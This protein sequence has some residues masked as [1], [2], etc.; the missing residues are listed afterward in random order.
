MAHN[1]R[2]ARPSKVLIRLCDAFT[3]TD[4]NIICPLIKAEI[5]IRVLYKLQ[6]KV[7]YKA[8]QEAGTGIGL[9]DPTFLWKSAATGREMDGNLFVEY[10]NSQRFN[11]NLKQYRET[12]VRNLKEVLKVKSILIDKVEDTDEIIPQPIISETCFE[13][14]KLKLCSERLD[15]DDF[16]TGATRS[17]AYDTIKSH[18]DDL[19]GQYTKFA[20]LSQNGRG[21]SFILNL[22]MLLTA[23]FEEE[24][25]ENNLNLKLPKDIDE[26]VK[27]EEIEK[28][29][30]LPDV[31]KDFLKTLSKEQTKECA[32]T[33]IGPLCCELPKVKEVQHSNNSLSNV[34]NYF[35]TNSRI[36]IDPY[37]LAQK[38]TEKSYES[39]TKCIIHLRY[40]TVYQM[41][42]NYFTEKDLQQQLFE[43]V[44]LNDEDSSSLMGET[45]KKIRKRA[46]ECLKARFEILTD[47]GSF[48]NS[49]EMKDKFQSPKDIVLSKEVQKLAGKT[50]LYIGNGK[51]A[52]YD[53]LAMRRILRKLT[54]YDSN[55]EY[56]KKKIAAVK[57]IMIYLPSKI[58]YGGKEILEMPGTDDSDP[59]AMYFIQTA[60]NEADAVIVISEFAFN[61]AEKEVKHML[62]SSDFA[63]YWKEKP[64]NYKLMLLAYPEKNQGW[65]YGKDDSEAITQ[66]EGEE[67]NKR[68]EE[69]RLISDIFKMKD[70]MDSEK[71]E[72]EENIIT[73]FILPVLHT[74]ILAQPTEQGEEYKVFQ[75][76]EKFLKHTG[77]SNLITEMDTFVSSRQ[78]STTEKIRNKFSHICQEMSDNSKGV[79][80][81]AR[82]VLCVLNN[83]EIKDTLE[84]TI[85]SNHKK[86]L[87][88]FTRGIVELLKEIVNTKVDAALKETV[89][90]A[91]TNWRRNENKIIHRGVFSP[92]F[93]GKNPVYK[94]LLYN[95]FFD[96][97]EDKKTRIFTEIKTRIE[98]LLQQYKGNI[99][100]QLT[101]DLNMVLG[102]NPPSFT[103]QFV[104]DAIGNE[105]DDALSW[106][107]GNKRRPFNVKTMRKCFEKSQNQCFKETILIPNFEKGIYV[108]SAK[109]NTER[110]IKECIMDIKESFLFLLTELHMDGLIS[111]NG[112]LKSK[113]SSKMWQRLVYKLK[114]FLRE[115]NDDYGEILND[116]MLMLEA[117]FDE[118]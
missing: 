101:N 109:E 57:Q 13:L 59:M 91:Q 81:A 104:Q 61:I 34:A 33:V 112:R 29:A 4:G 70:M 75:E 2:K 31:V 9:T 36:N 60:L 95:I 56:S 32:R 102:N 8:V 51:E 84:S 116:S 47:Y 74:S 97:L 22:L 1:P 15:P 24:Y 50:E 43:L 54:T 5:S 11:D 64:Y 14:H 69:L 19:K 72:L 96:G 63:K 118:P 58:L 73:A 88:N 17:V 27:L 114:V 115:S 6:E 76:N 98:A 65:Q 87:I 77:I 111:L 35:S 12:L 55:D 18:L 94:V 100:Q 40:G 37:I 78:K 21:K 3:R 93:I 41:S 90:Q 26:N 99:L 42:V 10:S 20:V 113:K 107:V 83:R 66:L 67:R 62:S 49:Q 48:T 25:G 16:D 23:D 80:E 117:N 92:F 30:D 108:K 39:T 53:R 71:E 7:L 110:N 85:N 82:T 44:T 38:A 68:T 105:L 52:H 46:Q 103:L 45:N 106:Y 28:Y 86:L 79:R 89:K